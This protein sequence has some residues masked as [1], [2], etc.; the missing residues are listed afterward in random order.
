MEEMVGEYLRDHLDDLADRADDLYIR[1][2]ALTCNLGNDH[3]ECA[4]QLLLGVL[5]PGGEEQ[6]ARGDL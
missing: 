2:T 6:I 3:F 5:L 4:V 1:N